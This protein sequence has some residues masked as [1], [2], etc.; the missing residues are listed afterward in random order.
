M[1]DFRSESFTGNET[2]TI[3]PTS[4][5]PLQAGTY[6]IAV[7]NFG[8]G[9]ANFTVTATITGG[10]AEAVVQRRITILKPK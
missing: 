7:V 6:F 4:A 8:P 3:T 9:A 2:I 10:P 5:P 1:A